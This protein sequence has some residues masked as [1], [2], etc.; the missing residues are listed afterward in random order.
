MSVVSVG[1]K[2]AE[3]EKELFDSGR[4]TEYYPLVHG[5]VVELAEAMAEMVHK[6]PRGAWHTKRRGARL[7]MK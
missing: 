2:I 6:N 4:Y 1:D 5:L 3:Y 7:W